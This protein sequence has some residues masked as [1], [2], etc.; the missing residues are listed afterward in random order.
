[1]PVY[2][3][4]FQYWR[5]I[6]DSNKVWREERESRGEGGDEHSIYWSCGYKYGRVVKRKKGNGELAFSPG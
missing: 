1:L 3:S 4:N 6:R 5:Y 2:F